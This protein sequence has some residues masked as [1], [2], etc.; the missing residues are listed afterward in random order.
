MAVFI[1]RRSRLRCGVEDDCRRLAREMS[2]RVTL[3]ASWTSGSLETARERRGLAC[4]ADLA[5]YRT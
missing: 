3:R 5:A 1:S 4:V 2:W